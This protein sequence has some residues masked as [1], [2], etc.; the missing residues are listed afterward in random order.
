VTVWF[1]FGR[2]VFIFTSDYFEDTHLSNN[3]AED[4]PRLTESAQNVHREVREYLD[5][6]P[7]TM[8]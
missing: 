6:R 1:V 3:A 5:T 2:H 7:N 4:C 8:Y